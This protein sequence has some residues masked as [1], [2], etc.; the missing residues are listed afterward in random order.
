MGT[1]CF[2][3]ICGACETTDYPGHTLNLWGWGAE[4]ASLASIS[5]DSELFFGGGGGCTACGILAPQPG[6]E[7]MPSAGK[8]HRILTTRVSTPREVPTELEH[9][10]RCRETGMLLGPFASH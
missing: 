9:L 1:T 3:A 7:A 4:A 6:I 10:Q 8:A 5:S 2:R